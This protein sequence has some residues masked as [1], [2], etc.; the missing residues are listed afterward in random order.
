MRGGPSIKHLDDVP[1][2]EML[3]YEFADGRTAS[4]WEK[5]IE[6][7]PRYV[8][9]W[10]KWD[11][12]AISPRH[13]HVG[14]HSNFILAGEIRCG[15]V[16]ARTGTHIMLEWGDVFGPWEAGPDG[17]ELYGF[18]AGEGQLFSGDTAAYEEL[19]K[20]RGAQSVPLPMPK[21]LPPWMLA[22]LG[23][24]F[25]SSVTQWDADDRIR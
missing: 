4:I 18:I 5:W 23:G 25:T 7:S 1:A 19:L 11:P 8:A 16:V 21:R 3:R 6:L 13:G 12:G 2:E 14:D 9:F 22:K 10:N 20:A 15:D 24:D 17:C